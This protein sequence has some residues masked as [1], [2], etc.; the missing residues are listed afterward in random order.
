MS[1][2]ISVKDRMPATPHEMGQFDPDGEHVVWEGLVSNS[3]EISDGYNLARGHY[4][5]DGEWVVYDAEHD[6]QLVDPA[7][8]THWMPLPEPPK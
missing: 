3:L 8:V 4:R 1:E 7:E 5:A 2:W 6:F